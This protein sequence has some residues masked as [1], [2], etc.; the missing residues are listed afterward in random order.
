MIKSSA[1]TLPDLSRFEDVSLRERSF[2]L[3]NPWPKRSPKSMMSHSSRLRHIATSQHTTCLIVQWAQLKKVQYSVLRPIKKAATQSSSVL[4]RR[5][6]VWQT[7]STPDSWTF[8]RQSTLLDHLRA[9]IGHWT[10]DQLAT[11]IWALSYPLE[12]WRGPWKSRANFNRCL[13]AS[14]HG[15]IW[16]QL[17]LPTSRWSS[18]SNAAGESNMQL[19]DMKRAE[20]QQNTWGWC[21]VYDHCF[22]MRNHS[23]SIKPP[24]NETLYKYLINK[25]NLC[26][27]TTAF[28]VAW[29]PNPIEPFGCAV[30]CGCS[31]CFTS[32][33]TLEATAS[34]VGVRRP[35]GS[36][37][38]KATGVV[39]CVCL[40]WDVFVFKVYVDLA[41]G[42]YTL[43]PW[44]DSVMGFWDWFQ[45]VGLLHA[46]SQRRAYLLTRK[47]NDWNAGALNGR[48]G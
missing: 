16:V 22:F 23:Y 18:I 34:P 41:P 17:R 35:E 9:E 24:Q 46:D 8:F 48:F 47:S 13:G 39:C 37:R 7:P 20:Y 32:W 40:E 45:P 36:R 33:P 4:L 15:A 12:D 1:Q 10:S 42:C 26:N 25:E 19:K 5:S 28:E 38:Q 44:S 6:T 27:P 43:L 30:A 21:C 2:S 11:R 29:G 3:P 31:D 14:P